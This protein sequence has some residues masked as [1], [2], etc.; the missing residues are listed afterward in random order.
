MPAFNEKDLGPCGHTNYWRD[1]RV[2]QLVFSVLNP[3]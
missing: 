2:W 3:E 1:L